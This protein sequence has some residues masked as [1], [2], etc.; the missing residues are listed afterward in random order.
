MPRGGSLKD[1]LI[2]FNVINSNFGAVN[3]FFNGVQ[4]EHGVQTPPLLVRDLF[5]VP[6]WYLGSETGATGVQSDDD[7]IHL[8][9]LDS[10]FDE[11]Q[12]V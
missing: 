4:T 9:S 7:K 5:R 8:F 3:D 10:S 6:A 12:G 2:I 11:I 1:P